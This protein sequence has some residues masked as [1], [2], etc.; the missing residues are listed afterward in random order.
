MKRVLTF[1][2]S[3]KVYWFAV[4]FAGICF[5]LSGIS[6]ACLHYANPT[7]AALNSV[8]LGYILMVARPIKEESA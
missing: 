7:T 5:I 3:P 8:F 2:S 1:L 6:T 4:R